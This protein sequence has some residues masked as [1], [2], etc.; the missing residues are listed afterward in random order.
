MYRRVRPKLSCWDTRLCFG[1]V[2]HLCYLP[3][4]LV[5]GVCEQSEK[6]D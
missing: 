6:W 3:L 5:L 1:L 2:L 4:V